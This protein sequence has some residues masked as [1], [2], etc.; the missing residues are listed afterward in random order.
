M[1]PGVETEDIIQRILMNRMKY[2]EIQRKKAAKQKV[3]EMQR[4]Y[5]IKEK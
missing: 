5:S 4:D 1:E 3:Y 2:M